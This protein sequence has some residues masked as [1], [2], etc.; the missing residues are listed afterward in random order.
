MLLPK[1]TKFRKLHRGRRK[2][3]ARRGCK[4]EY[5]TIGLQALDP[6][7]ITNRQLESGRKTMSRLARKGGRLII[8]T[9][10]DIVRS[11]K[12]AETRQG[13]GKGNPEIWVAVVRPGK[14]IY[15]LDGIPHDQAKI[16]LKNAARKL[17][18]RTTIIEEQE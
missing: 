1:R 10:P 3:V 8:R 11:K 14:I 13:G 15:E 17:P 2:G 12:P 9:F 6:G 16:A 7:D 18:I 5:G 4:L